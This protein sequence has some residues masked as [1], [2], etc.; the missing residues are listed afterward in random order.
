M[1][2]FGDA[3]ADPWHGFLPVALAAGVGGSVVGFILSRLLNPQT[4]TTGNKGA[5]AAAVSAD[6]ETFA[7]A[8]GESKMV[9]C[10]RTD[11]KMQK[12]KTGAQIGHAVLGG[13]KRAMKR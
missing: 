3:A 1:A 8:G 13:Y 9:L 12:G 4:G 10:V 5:A 11:L 2:S 7:D 6:R